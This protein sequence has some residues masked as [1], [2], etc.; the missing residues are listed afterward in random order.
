MTGWS[1]RV[2]RPDEVDAALAE[3]PND[4][5]ALPTGLLVSL[6]DELTPRRGRAK[7]EPGS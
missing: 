5:L 2:V 1:T 4:D 6:R 7:T 3:D